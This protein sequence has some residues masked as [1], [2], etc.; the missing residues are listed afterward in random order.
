M[1]SRG[2]R[3]QPRALRRIPSLEWRARITVNSHH[4]PS[5]T[6][7]LSLIHQRNCRCNT[8]KL[9]DP[10]LRGIKVLCGSR[11]CEKSLQELSYNRP[12][13]GMLLCFKRG[14][15]PP[16]SFF[17]AIVSLDLGTEPSHQATVV[18]QPSFTHS[19][20]MKGQPVAERRTN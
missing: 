8:S 5:H 15:W 6:F 12:L 10:D 3:S 17:T 1:L 7:F 19:T 20:K 9:K 16:N 2:D 11:L 13:Y 18:H 4:H 14:G